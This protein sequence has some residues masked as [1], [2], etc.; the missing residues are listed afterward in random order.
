MVDQLSAVTRE[1][2]LAFADEAFRNRDITF[3]HR[4]V[5]DM[6]GALG[7]FLSRHRLASVS[8]ASAEPFLAQLRRVNLARYEAWVEG[9]DA[10]IMFDALELGG[11]VGELLNVVKKL[12]RE[13]RG[14]RGS[15]EAPKDFADEC[16]DVLICLDKL[17]RR[18]NVDLTA[19]TISK[20]NA[21]SEKVGLSHRLEASVGSGA[22]AE[23]EV[24]VSVAECV[25]PRPVGDSK[26]VQVEDCTGPQRGA[27]GVPRD[28]AGAHTK[29]AQTREAFLAQAVTNILPIG[30]SRAPGDRV[31]PIYVR[32][33][34]LR[35]L[36]ELAAVS[37]G[38]AK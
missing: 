29:G 14:W 7:T 11:E 38:A 17:A 4:D 8:S 12:E 22:P 35:A 23:Q 10:G 16:A 24:S 6:V 27:E 9:A 30:D 19:V 36:R 37:V 21:T 18:R 31:I 5:V 25:E 28:H 13:E 1:D 3:S 20:F 26:I 32:M 15:R 34:E 2:A 33:D